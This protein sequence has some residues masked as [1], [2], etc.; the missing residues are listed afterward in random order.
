MSNYPQEP[1]GTRI[2]WDAT[3][4]VYE[5]WA[6]PNENVRTWLGAFDDYH[7][8]LAACRDHDAQQDDAEQARRDHLADDP[9]IT[10]DYG[11]R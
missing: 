10:R 5:A 7:E 8:A 11:H 4:R 3:A 6:T 9:D 2:E 1:K